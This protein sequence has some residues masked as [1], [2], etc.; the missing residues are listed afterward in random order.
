MG[1]TVVIVTHDLDTLW[2][3]T[4]RV[5]FLGEGRV[6]AMDPMP[7]LVRNNNPLIQAFFNGP[8]GRLAAQSYDAGSDNRGHSH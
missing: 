6:L 1:L 2:T 3:V 5:V 7:Q 4:D 8:R